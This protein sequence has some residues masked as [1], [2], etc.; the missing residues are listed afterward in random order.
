MITPQYTY[1]NSG[2]KIGVFLTIDDWNELQQIPGVNESALKDN[3]IPDWQMK[4]GL[5]E[6]ENIASG[7]TE[8]IPWDEAKEQFKI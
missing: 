6:L 8:L 2:N 5:K 3:K 4:L 7:K 1:D